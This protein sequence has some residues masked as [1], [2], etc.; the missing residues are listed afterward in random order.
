[1]VLERR[2]AA[3]PTATVGVL[4]LAD[5]SGYTW[6]L[7][8]VE[9]AH[10]ADI[11]GGDHVP[12]AYSFISSLLD[13]I[14]GSV[15]PPFELS[16]L[17]GD[18]VFAWSGDTTVT[19]RG[20]DL[21]TFIARCY[22]AFQDQLGR[23]REIWTCPCGSCALIG[24]LDLKFVLH[25]GPFVVQS[26]AGRTELV[27]PTVV[28]AHRLLKSQA[29]TLVGHGAYALVTDAAAR[30]LDVPTEGSL[31]LLE[32]IEHYTPVQAHVYS[33]PDLRLN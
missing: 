6:F 32:A 17:E 4:F 18:A 25:A 22:G 15:V 27:G 12:D 3:S 8:S 13:G 23:A 1:M 14:I 9:E 2:P 5:I 33:V 19:P 16:K 29:A 10:R 21:L 31:P 7:R 24:G 30:Q 26:I 28:M 20:S 11:F